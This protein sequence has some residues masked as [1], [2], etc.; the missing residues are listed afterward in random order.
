M[1]HQERATADFQ[2]GR[3]CCQ[4]VVSAFCQEMG[5]TEEQAHDLGINYG[6]GRYQGLCGALVGNDIVV[7]YLKGTPEK[8]DPAKC[9]NDAAGRFQVEMT[10]A[11]EQ[12]TGSLYCTQLLGK[13]PCLEYVQTAVEILE[14]TLAET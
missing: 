1:D 12:E 13:K 11:F 10:Q 9:K 3:N 7:N 2:A 14:R 6:G 8:D 4:A 5:I